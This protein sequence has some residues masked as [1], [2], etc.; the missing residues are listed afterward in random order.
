MSA[1]QHHA[2][3]L[4]GAVRMTVLGP[5]GRPDACHCSQCRRQSGHYWASTNVA[6]SNLV[7]AGEE[8]INWYQSSPTVRRGF[9]KTCGSF[10]LWDGPGRE[11][12]AIAMGAFAAPTKTK[13]AV[14]IYVSDKGDYYD[15]DDGVPQESTPADG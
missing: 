9:C 13:L 8:S 2:M 12:I 14:H 11:R 3:C 15:I 7:I 1:A 4:C 10:L 5:L 6:R